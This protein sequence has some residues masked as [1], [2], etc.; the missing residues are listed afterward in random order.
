V[1]S[2]EENLQRAAQTVAAQ[3]HVN[4]TVYSDDV[5]TLKVWIQL[6]LEKTGATKFSEEE[7]QDSTR[8]A[9]DHCS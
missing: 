1:S 2:I 6:Y 5:A 8:W 4:G 9:L 7:E 3:L